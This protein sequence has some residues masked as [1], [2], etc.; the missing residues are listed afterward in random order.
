MNMAQGIC[1]I[2]APISA[3]FAVQRQTSAEFP[4]VLTN[5]WSKAFSQTSALE[6]CLYFARH[7]LRKRSLFLL[8]VELIMSSLFA[9]HVRHHNEFLGKDF[10]A[11]QMWNIWLPKTFSCNPGAFHVSSG[12]R[13]SRLSIEE[14][15]GITS[16]WLRTWDS[17][18]LWFDSTSWNSPESFIEF[19]CSCKDCNCEVSLCIVSQVSLIFCTENSSTRSCWALFIAPNS[20]IFRIWE[21]R[22][23]FS[24]IN[25]SSC[26]RACSLRDSKNPCWASCNSNPWA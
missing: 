4:L 19:I 11:N 1:R 6:L 3:V 22:R 12:K 24:F 7:L 13:L 25:N 14:E 23:S 18:P 21:S 17:L 20:W 2:A 9:F 15:L 10:G 26:R 16:C 5:S 8:L